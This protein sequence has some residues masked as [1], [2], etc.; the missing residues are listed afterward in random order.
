MSNQHL[1]CLLGPAADRRSA[2]AIVLNMIWKLEASPIV[3]QVGV[4]SDAGA[5][6][7]RFRAS[8]ARLVNVVE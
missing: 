2:L 1:I 8:I 6:P 5:R 3:F 4:P 7:T